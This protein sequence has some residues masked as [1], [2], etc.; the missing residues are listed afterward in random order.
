MSFQS[1]VR[2]L[3]QY[4]LEILNNLHVFLFVL[5]IS[6]YL[7]IFEN[8]VSRM[9]ECRSLI[10]SCNYFEFSMFS[11]TFRRLLRHIS[12]FIKFSGIFIRLYL[13]LHLLFNTELSVLRAGSSILTSL[14]MHDKFN[15]VME[16]LELYSFQIDLNISYIH[17]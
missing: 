2:F 9:A 11:I 5:C 8:N 13:W 7:S 16:G 12:D 15:V 17:L 4:G 1:I 6:R 10:I 3:F 14:G